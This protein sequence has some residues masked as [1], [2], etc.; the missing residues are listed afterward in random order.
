MQDGQTQTP[1]FRRWHFG[2]QLAIGLVSRKQDVIEKCTNTALLR[3]DFERCNLLEQSHWFPKA[4][5]MPIN[6]N[7]HVMKFGPEIELYH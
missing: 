5:P 7:N 2:Q 3:L 1:P 4:L 6:C